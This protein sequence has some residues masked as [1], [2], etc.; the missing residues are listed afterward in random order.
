[1]KRQ[2]WKTSAVLLVV[3]MIEAIAHRGEGTFA[4]LLSDLLKS[5]VNKKSVLCQCENLRIHVNSK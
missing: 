2:L 3:A 4:I 1:M 5:C